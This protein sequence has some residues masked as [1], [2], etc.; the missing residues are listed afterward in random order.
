[1]LAKLKFKIEDILFKDKNFVEFENLPR[2]DFAEPPAHIDGD[3]SSTWALTAAKIIKKNPLD[4][5]KKAA[6]V[7]EELEEVASATITAPGF[8]NIKL[9]DSYLVQA[10]RDRRL[11]N[12]DINPN[13]ISK[14]KILIEFVSANPTGPLHVASG[15]GASLGDS[16][17]RIHRA[18]GI[19]CDAEYY[20]NDA[21]NQAELLGLSL[22]A[23]A[24]GKEPP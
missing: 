2:I 10:A 21:G 1:M 7:I 22:Q 8:I 20:I 13:E 4:I 3:L 6:K 19:A 12:R 5:A 23:R 18:I 9:K 11:K 24:Q 14:E 17:V 15:R 16:L